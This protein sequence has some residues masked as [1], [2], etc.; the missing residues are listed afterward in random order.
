M[1]KVFVFGATGTVGFAVAT[2]LVRNGYSVYGLARTQ[3]KAKRLAQNEVVPVIGTAQD[4]SAWKDTVKRC[5][6]IIEAVL[7][8][9]DYTTGATLQQSLLPF[10]KED[11]SKLLIATSGGLVYGKQ[12][13]KVLTELDDLKPEGIIQSRPQFERTYLDAGA[14]V[15]RLM[16]VY[17]RQGSS[18]NFYFPGVKAGKIEL[19]VTNPDSHV[20]LVHIDDVAQAFVKAV[21]KG[22]AFRGQV[23]NIGGSNESW[24]EC[25]AAVAAAV[26]LKEPIV[27]VKPQTMF[28]QLFD[29]D[30]RISSEKAKNLLG[31]NPRHT[32]FCDKAG[33]HYHSWLAHQ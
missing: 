2:E 25:A 22:N 30:M 20:T 8:M 9:Q 17:G 15:L 29:T 21:E 31:W 28:Q 10:L 11:K 19:P 32:S 33:L 26:G 18:G 6:V 24:K 12:P 3:E 27:F 23:F 7:D 16:A 14:V 1:S 4:S 5:D 13:G